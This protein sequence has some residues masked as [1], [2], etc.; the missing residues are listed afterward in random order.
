MV[1][2]QINVNPMLVHEAQLGNKISM[3]QLTAAA[4]DRLFAY[5]Y[6]LTLD[7]PLTEDLTQETLLHMVRSI[8]QLEEP[9]KFWPWLFRTAL[10]KVQHHWRDMKRKKKANLTEHEKH[11]IAD[12]L[13]GQFEDGLSE[14]LRKELS[15]A[16]FRA[17]KQLKFKYRS[18]LVL[19]CFEQLGYAEI[20]NV[21]NCSELQSR[22][23]FFRAKNALKR[24]LAVQ[25]FG[26]RYFMAGLALFAFITAST[27][28]AYA[29]GG[30]TVATI[31]VG[32]GPAFLASI[33]TKFGII[34]AG[35]VAFFAVMV[36]LKMFLAGLGIAVVIFVVLVLVSLAAVY[37]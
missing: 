7:Y 4:K 32:F 5:I 15:D 25:G 14:M 34:A 30:L 36:P 18:V 16:V 33:T 22:V 37:R 31:E 10:G 11:R 12:R 13:S 27:K 35:L 23:M 17:I 20:G 28:T 8:S 29:S 1:G 2:T 6:R 19:R 26:R 21:L 24:Q 3:D 9:A